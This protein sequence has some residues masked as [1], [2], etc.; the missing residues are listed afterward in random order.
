MLRCSPRD[1]RDNAAIGSP[2]VPVVISTTCSGAIISAAEMSIRSESSTCRKPRS[3]A[4]PML[5][6]ID[7]PTKDTRRPSAT[8]ALMICCT[9]S[10]LEAK[11]ATITRSAGAADQPVQRRAHL[12]FGWPDSGH[13]RIGRIAQEQVHTGVAQPGHA[14]QIG[15]TA[16][17]R[18]LIE[19]DVAGLQNGSRA[20]VDGDGQRVRDGVVNGEVLAFEHAVPAALPLGDLDE[21]RLDAVLAAFRGDHRQGE[22]RVRQPGCRGAT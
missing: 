16:V 11:H 9:R 10:T 12:A 2:W 4:I 6:T 1:I 5:R 8:A 20:G 17:Q 22:L 15:R 21:H 13:L 3:R 14:G 19:L 7:R 18:L